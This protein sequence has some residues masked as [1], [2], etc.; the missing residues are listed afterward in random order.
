MHGGQSANRHYDIQSDQSIAHK[1]VR[2][3][4]CPEKSRRRGATP[5]PEFRHGQLSVT[6][7]EYLGIHKNESLRWRTRGASWWLGQRTPFR[8]RR[9]FRGRRWRRGGTR[10]Q[11][12]RHHIDQCRGSS[13]S[14]TAESPQLPSRLRRGTV[15]QRSVRESSQGFR[16]VPRE[17]INRRVSFLTTVRTKVW[18]VHES[19]RLFLFQKGKS[20]LKFR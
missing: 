18:T 10:K 12:I 17:I 13:Q 1:I 6:Q 8:D 16:V 15:G 14:G 19:G 5:T 20:W 4:L 7:S 11:P 2:E 3:I 9:N